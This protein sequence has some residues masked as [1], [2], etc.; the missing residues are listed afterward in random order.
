VPSLLDKR[1]VL[2]TGKGGTG[3]TTVSIALGLAAAR[4]GKRTI[5][6]E[7]GGQERMSRAFKR[8]GVGYT[9]TELEANLWGISI[10]PDRAL[11]EY[12]EHQVG[13]KMLSGLLFNNRLFQYLAA[14]APGVRELAT[15]ATA[16]ERAQPERHS[17]DL[18]ILDAPATGHAL[19][20]LRTPRMFADI[21]RV[22]PI[23][24]QAH[25]IDSFVHD[26]KSTG[27]LV[28]ALPEEMPVNE[29]LEFRDALR[30]RVGLKVDSVVV[31]GLFPERFS[32]AD[33]ERIDLAYG[34]Q[35][36]PAVRS[37]L[38]AALSEHDRARAQ[39]TQLRRMR[40]EVDDVATLPF[41][42]DPELRL[43]AFERLSLELERKV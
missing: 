30:D 25:K 27:V 6:C 12:L 22:G 35:D 40:R 32:G 9:E 31:N 16:W 41:L 43:E 36:A 29:T 2:V 1:L 24:R 13:S 14:A 10:E 38:G 28:V 11:Q 42:F 3:K 17:F 4:A 39:R 20:M 34:D 23:K 19:G 18:V 15:L 5:V 37:A 7:V 26:R 8:K 21:A 33:A